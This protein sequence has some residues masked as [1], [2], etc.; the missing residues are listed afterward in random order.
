MFLANENWKNSFASYFKTLLG[1]SFAGI[2]IIYLLSGFNSTNHA[3]Y[4]NILKNKIPFLFIPV[5]LIAVKS[6]KKEQQ[7]LIHYFFILC[8][9]ISSVWSYIQ[10]LP[11][12]VLYTNLYAEGKVI[13]TLI[14]HVSLSVLICIAVLFVLYNLIKVSSIIEKFINFILLIWFIYFIHILSVRTGIVL[15]YFSV[16]LFGII[17]LFTQKKPVFTIGLILLLI[18]SAAISYQKIPTIKSKIAYTI[19]GISQYKN[20][21]D[22]TNQ[23]SDSRRILSDKI[24]IELIQKNKLSGVGLGDI[25]DEMN[26]IYQQRF[27]QFKK[28]VFS[29]IHNQYLYAVCGVGIILGVLFCICLLLPLI[30]FVKE[31]NW[32][33]SLAYL[34]LLL[35]MCWEPFIENQLGTS[36]FLVVSC[37]GFLN[38]KEA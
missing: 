29:H 5:S 34:M 30:Q 31:K 2:F 24:G 27:P 8:C 18:F 25:Q 37:L 4:F 23:V 16:F 21:Q 9:L 11:N 19:Y 17:T 14:H 6:L 7:K 26:V 38:N 13:P 20:Q 35:L 32:I 33:Y 10:Y 12:A 15:L 3:E 28:D 22:T 1:I 36:I